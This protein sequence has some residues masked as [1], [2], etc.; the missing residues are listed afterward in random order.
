MK[1]KILNKTKVDQFLEEVG[2]KCAVWGPKKEA[3]KIAFDRIK[4]AKEMHLDGYMNT[5]M[6]PKNIFFPQS[7][8]MLHFMKSGEDANI[9]KEVEK[10]PA[11]K[12]VFGIRPCDAAAFA[13]L[14]KIFRN[15][16]YTDTYWFEKR[17]AA[18]LIGLGCNTPCST[19][20]CTS[21]NSH[22]FGEKGLDVLA[23]DLGD[24]YLL[25]IL[26]EKG[27]KLLD[28]IASLDD[29]K[30]AD[31][32]GQEALSKKA[33]DSITT[34]LSQERI[35]EKSVLELYNADCWSRIHES[36]L[37]CGTCT[38][39][40]PT[41]HCFDIQDELFRDGGVRIRNWDS[42]MSWLFTIHATGHN[43][44]PSKKERVRQRF[45]HK[46]KYIPIKRDGDIGC[47]GCGRCVNLC[48]VNIDIR[49]VV[50]EMNA[51]K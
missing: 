43:P 16:Q 51:S 45:M 20:F 19:C 46:F 2:K 24:R 14:D 17:D 3:D 26:T 9:Y 32:S 49:E 39:V 35:K 22:P 48:P 25:K 37:N 10:K 23:S 47:V 15:D 30:D 13:L 28:G 31:I 50:Q 27:E 29:A 40:C 42:C 1:Y 6:S 38:F 12:A 36:C 5:S 44:R 7:E 4:D 33:E 41:C 18:T 34:N 11:A 8:T 21:V